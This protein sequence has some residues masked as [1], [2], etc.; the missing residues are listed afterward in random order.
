MNKK[1]SGFV[2]VIVFILVISGLLLWSRALKNK[3]E[4]S[5]EDMTS[6]E[7]ALRMTMD[8]ATEF[9]IHPE[10]EVII[11]GEKQDIPPNIGVKQNGMTALHTHEGGGVIH[12]ESPIQKD[13][14]V[15]DFFAV[16]GKI[17][18]KDQII[19]SVVDESHQIIVTVNGSTVDT[20]ENT[21][22]N[23]N[24]KIIISYVKK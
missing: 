10:I 4:K 8:M 3:T 1:Y 24:D 18:T 23:D 13:F 20:F 2:I 19:N 11:N 6:R 7:V 22:M 5:L 15:G 21:V 9:H 12:V 17:F 14:T 16:W